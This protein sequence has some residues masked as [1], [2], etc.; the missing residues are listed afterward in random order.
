MLS[1]PLHTLL[2][3]N[4][5]DE[6]TPEGRFQ[7][8]FH[9]DLLSTLLDTRNS[10]QCRLAC[11]TVHHFDKCRCHIYSSHFHNFVLWHKIYSKQYHN[12]IITISAWKS[13]VLTWSSVQLFSLFSS[14]SVV[15]YF[16]QFSIVHFVKQTTWRPREWQCRCDFR[17]FHIILASETSKAFMPTVLRRKNGKMVLSCPIHTADAIRQT[18]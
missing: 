6:D 18:E 10:A 4:I 7:A 13:H 14:C 16:Q 1:V 15:H 11:D 5:P 2:C 3:L 17:S 8:L 12:N 9:T